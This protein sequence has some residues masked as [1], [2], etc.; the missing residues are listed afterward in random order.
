MSVRT[1]LINLPSPNEPKKELQGIHEEDHYVVCTE[2]YI[3]WRIPHDNPKML[4]EEIAL[5]IQ[6]ARDVGFRMGREYVCK[7][8]GCKFEE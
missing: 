3:V 7:A 2:N 5:A 6:Q 8:L 1:R 4:A